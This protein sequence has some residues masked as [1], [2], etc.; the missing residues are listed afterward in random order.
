M[1]T[2]C[3]ILIVGVTGK[4]GRMLAEQLCYRNRVI[5]VS[6]FS[7][8]ET[9]RW[10]SHLPIE[11]ICLDVA[12][13]DIRRL[14]KKVDYVFLEFA[15]MHGAE[16]DPVRA[17]AV[18]VE[19][20]GRIAEYYQGVKGMV[21]ASTGSVYPRTLDG[22]DEQTRPEPQGVYSLNRFAQEELLRYLARRL[23][24][25]MV[26]LR[27]FHAYTEK[28]GFVPRLAGQI[29]RGE[30]IRFEEPYRNVI[31]Q[32]DLVNYT[33]R[34]VTHCSTEPPVINLCGPEKVNLAQLAQYL[35]EQLKCEP[36]LAA[37][38]L[39]ALSLLGRCDKMQQFFGAPR[40]SLEEGVRRVVHRIQNQS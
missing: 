14:P 5:G 36:N 33:I 15:L 16:D 27:Y 12:E 10:V 23:K 21:V 6:T 28:E 35:G 2:D 20:P 11:P 31:W 39:E 30:E 13:D 29:Q 32:E 7:N 25:P 4:V 38:P 24:I 37:P 17:W 9:R 8:P 26:F 1:L 22:A 19:A 34:S 3:R 18:N 40:V